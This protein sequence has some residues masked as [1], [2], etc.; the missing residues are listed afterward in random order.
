MEKSDISL[1]GRALPP[2][3]QIR[4][5]LVIVA[6][7]ASALVIGWG[8]LRAR[9]SE[10]VE[11]RQ[12]AP[13]NE[14]RLSAV[15]LATLEFDPVTLRTFRTEEATDGRIALNGDTTTEVFSPYSGRVVRVM[16]APG[17]YVR[18][19]APLLRIEATEF[20]EAQTDLLNTAATLRLA[21]INEER[22]HAAYDGKGGSQQDWQQ[23]QVDL[24]AAETAFRHAIEV[25]ANLAH[26]YGQLGDVL[27]ATGRHADAVAMRQKARS[28]A[29][30]PRSSNARA[31]RT[32]SKVAASDSIARSARTLRMSGW[33]INNFPKASRCR[34]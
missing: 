21:R 18:Q 10:P 14:L 8:V 11:T 5:V 4:V 17:E 27:S 31:S 1:L 30:D 16:A 12:A 29:S 34:A 25:N 9:A 15:Q 3:K 2:G 6:I 13:A 28:W 22:R 24:A 23:A 33:S 20:V 7:A 32:M 19:G 26:P